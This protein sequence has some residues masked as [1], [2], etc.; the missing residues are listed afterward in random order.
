[1]HFEVPKAKK[2][3]EFGGEYIMIVISILTAL[4]LEHGAQSLH[5]QR[6]VTQAAA[7]MDA[8]LRFNLDDLDK[9]LEHNR[10]EVE[11]L[12]AIR[13]TLLADIRNGASDAEVM[14]RFLKDPKNHFGLSIRTPSFN[15]EAWDVAVANQAATWMPAEQLRR[16]STAYGAMRDLQQ[17]NNGGGGLG[18]LSGPAYVDVASNIE[19]RISNPH[20]I[21]RIINQM[22]S[23]YGSVDGN[24]EGLQRQLRASTGGKT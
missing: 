24:L 17:L 11:K 15:R 6:L 10:A 22:I 7:N 16:Y 12:K 4:A 9:V 13:A 1:M 18:F 5:H 8:E 20:E 3:K 14:E 21:Y 2:F 19:M 23:A